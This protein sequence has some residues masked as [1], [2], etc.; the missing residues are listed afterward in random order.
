MRQT[1]TYTLVERKG[2][3]ARLK[4]EVD[5]PAVRNLAQTDLQVV[6]SATTS[7][8]QLNLDLTKPLPVKVG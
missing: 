6:D 7:T 1:V 3:A 5:R 4:V 8:G 2:Q